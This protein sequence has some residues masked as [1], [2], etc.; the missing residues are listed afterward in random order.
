MLSPLLLPKSIII[1][2]PPSPLP[3]SPPRTQ[4][5]IFTPPG[6]AK[7]KIIMR[8]PLPL[9]CPSGLNSSS[10]NKIMLSPLL[11]PNSIIIIFPP[12]P[13]PVSPPRTQTIIFTPP[14]LAKEIIIMRPPPPPT[15][16]LWLELLLSK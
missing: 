5:I 2:F 4:T 15:P 14:G 12:S 7:K 6:L 13:L 10:A 9:P 16:P 3:V 11:L 8:P 1:I